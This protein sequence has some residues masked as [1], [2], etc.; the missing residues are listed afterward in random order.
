MIEKEMEYRGSKSGFISKSVKEQRVDGSW[1]FFNNKNCLRCT[2]MGIERYYQVKNLSKQI[3]ALRTY[4]SATHMPNIVKTLNT[5]PWFVTGFTDAEGSF[6]VLIQHNSAYRLNWRIKVIFAI[7]L[8]NKDIELLQKIQSYFGVGKLHKHGE[9]S[10]QYRVESVKDMQVIIDHFY[11]YPLISTKKVNYV[12]FKKALSLIKLEDHIDQLDLLKLV[13]IKSH[14][15]LGLNRELKQAFPDWSKY[16]ITKPEYVF[17][18]IPDPYWVAGFASGDGSFSIKVSNNSTTTI[19]NRIQLRFAI[20]LSI[21]EKELIISLANYFKSDRYSSVEDISKGGK[22]PYV[23]YR[24]DSV[25]LEIV[26]FSDVYNIII[27]FFSKYPIEGIKSLD[28]FDFITVANMITNK[29]H[30]TSE[31]FDKVMGIKSLMNKNR[32]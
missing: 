25:N 7:G 11:E 27:P 6:S 14:L 30:L 24:K 21:I 20:G 9:N 19:G 16:Q 32:I 3:N 23:Y 29:E 18:G 5:N 4:K 10:T 15:N 26:R 28:L 22:M 2:L 31:G 17:T 1:Q 13:G 8:H 12:L